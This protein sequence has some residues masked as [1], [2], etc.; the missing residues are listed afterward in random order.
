[1]ALIRYSGGKSEPSISVKKTGNVTGG[2]QTISITGVTV[3][4]Y[5]LATKL[6]F[7]GQHSTA[8]AQFGP[9]TGA[10]VVD[11]NDDGLV[12]GTAPETI[13]LK[14]TS[15]TVSYSHKSSNAG[16]WIVFE[17]E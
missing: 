15:T 17:M 8:E 7:S 16:V 10:T 1:M 11:F 3:G 9:F 2:A 6:A 14:A 13:V 5:I 4:Q 12:S